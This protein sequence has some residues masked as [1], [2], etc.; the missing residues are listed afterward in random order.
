MNVERLCVWLR[1]VAPTGSRRLQWFILFLFFLPSTARAATVTLAW[2]AVDDP[3]AAGYVLYY[4]YSPRDYVDAIDVGPQTTCTLI[5]LPDGIVLYFAVTVYDIDGNES[6]F[7][8]E[9]TQDGPSEA[10]DPDEDG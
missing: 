9:I 7:S 4:G 8:K 1:A 2:E 10:L 3:E 6:G 5:N